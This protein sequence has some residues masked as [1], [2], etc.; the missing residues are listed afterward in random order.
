MDINQIL[1]K[2]REI[3]LDNESRNRDLK[4]GYENFP[5]FLD[6]LVKKNS[7]LDECV[8]QNPDLS[9]QFSTWKQELNNHLMMYVNHINLQRIA[10]IEKFSFVL[11][12]VE[13]IQKTVN[14]K[15]LCE[16]MK[17]QKLAAL[18]S[19]AIQAN[20]N[21]LDVIQKCF[22][23]QSEILW[24]T[25]CDIK[26]MLTYRSQASLTQYEQ[27]LPDNVPELERKS[28]ELLEKLI[29][30][31]FVVERQPAQIIIYARY[32]GIR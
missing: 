1:L 31:S 28:I 25:L 3:A 21:Q 2:L 23:P 14:E 19:V 27:N 29:A 20:S 7:Y 24:K 32:G 13:K 15:F 10:L 22:E 12:E 26:T 30:S 11:I 9:S 17:E 5:S 18:K 4:L 8:L 6:H 16:W